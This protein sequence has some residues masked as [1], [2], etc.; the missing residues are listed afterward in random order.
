MHEPVH[1][2][3]V[4]LTAS[5]LGFGP[6]D[7]FELVLGD[8]ANPL[9]AG[10]AMFTVREYYIDWQTTEPATFTIECLDPPAEPP[11]LTDAD[12]AARFGDAGTA[13]EHSITYWNRYL[14][15]VHA[16]G[17]PNTFQPSHHGAKGLTLAQYL[18]CPFDLGPDDALVIEADVPPARYW[19]LHLYPMGTFEHVDLVDRVTSLNQVQADIGD[20]GRLR[21]VVG[22]GD[23]GVANWLD[24]GGRRR[25]LLIYRWF[26]PTG[27][28]TPEP[29]TDVV[30]IATLGGPVTPEDRAATMAARRSHLAWRFR[31]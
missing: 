4:D 12:L 19:S 6:G 10:A 17:P 18:F 15:D 1:G 16:A 20:D 22:A 11:V 8:D 24:T 27:D 28:R 23:P 31:A 3:L 14:E 13:I 21:V 25:G 29:V 5:E 30:P 26:W 9:P 2:T 7:D